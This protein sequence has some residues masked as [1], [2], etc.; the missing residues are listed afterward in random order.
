MLGQTLLLRRNCRIIAAVQGGVRSYNLRLV[1]PV[2]VRSREAGGGVLSRCIRTMVGGGAAALRYPPG[3]AL[4]S[5]LAGSV[6]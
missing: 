5:N 3:D 6:L 4:G 2:C 1:V